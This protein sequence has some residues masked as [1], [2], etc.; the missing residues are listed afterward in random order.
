MSIITHRLTVYETSDVILCIEWCRSF[1]NSYAMVGSDY[2][3]ACSSSLPSKTDGNNCQRFCPLGQPCGG[4]NSI[5]SIYNIGKS[6]V[7]FYILKTNCMLT[8]SI[9]RKTQWTL[10]E[11]LL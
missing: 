6:C 4:D 11:S 3:C 2:A 7:C 1:D 8:S 5:V 9:T 10:T